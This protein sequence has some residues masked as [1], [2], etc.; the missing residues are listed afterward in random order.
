MRK[1]MGTWDRSVRMALVALS[2]VLIVSGAVKAALAVV[3]G[4]L[5]AILILTSL[6]G[7]CPLYTPFRISTKK[8]RR[9]GD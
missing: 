3:L 1:N 8:R 2:V 9:G 7:Y 5:A 6:T 4:I